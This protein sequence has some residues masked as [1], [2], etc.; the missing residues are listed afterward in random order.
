MKLTLK[1]SKDWDAQSVSHGWNW[2]VTRDTQHYF[3]IAKGWAAERKTA[4]T[5]GEQ[6]VARYREYLEEKNYTA[7]F[8][9]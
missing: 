4:I 1:V 9:L 8:E 6:A 2:D 7:E 5:R 3:S